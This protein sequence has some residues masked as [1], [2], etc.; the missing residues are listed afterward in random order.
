MMVAEALAAAAAFDVVEGLV[1]VVV[2]PEMVVLS[3]D[4]LG[5]G[6]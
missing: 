4:C 5:L 6:D 2:G 3:R 1:A